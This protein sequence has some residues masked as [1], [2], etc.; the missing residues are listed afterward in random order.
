MGGAQDGSKDLFWE[1]GGLCLHSWGI[2][3]YAY[4]SGMG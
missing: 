4:T 1:R 2:P 3:A